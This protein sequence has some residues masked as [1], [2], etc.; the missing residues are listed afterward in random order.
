MQF[1]NTDYNYFVEIHIWRAKMDNIDLYRFSYGNQIPFWK[2]MDINEKEKTNLEKN[3]K[4]FQKFFAFSNAYYPSLGRGYYPI[5]ILNNANYPYESLHFHEFPRK[6]LSPTFKAWETS[7]DVVLF[8][9]ALYAFP[10]MTLFYIGTMS[11]YSLNM[12]RET[13]VWTKALEKTGE[14][15]KY[16]FLPAEQNNDIPWYETYLPPY[17]NNIFYVF[18]E[19]MENPYWKLNSE[20]IILPS[21]NPA[22]SK[23]IHDVLKNIRKIPLKDLDVIVQTN[24]VPLYD[25]FNKDKPQYVLKTPEYTWKVFLLFLFILLSILLVQIMLEKKIDKM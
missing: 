24:S 14:K 9:V 22:D 21:E 4:L 20:S 15:K 18:E 6:K 7:K 1:P 11:E 2:D 13:F 12:L 8:T 17:R 10:K 16:T 5:Y 23:T 25:I 3:W 19:K